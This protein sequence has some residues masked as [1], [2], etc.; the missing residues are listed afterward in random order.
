MRSLSLSERNFSFFFFFWLHCAFIAA[1]R[2][3]LAEES[4]GY[5]LFSTGL[6]LWCTGLVAPR[7]VGSS[8]TRVQMCVSCIGKQ[9]LNHWTIREVLGR[10]LL[11]LGLPASLS[12][13]LSLP[14]SVSA[15]PFCVPDPLSQ[16]PCASLSSSL[17]ITQTPV[18]YKIGK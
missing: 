10:I 18:H 5:S 12:L 3:S 16:G 4:G 8:W 2:L 13:S 14:L 15:S 11:S 1:G 7:H 9:V 6:L 17:Y